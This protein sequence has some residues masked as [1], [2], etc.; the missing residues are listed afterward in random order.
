MGRSNYKMEKIFIVDPV[1]KPRMT[2]RDHWKNRPIV[3]RY[4]A[5]KDMISLQKWEFEF[6]EKGAQVIFQIPMPKSW[7][8]KKKLKMN[9]TDHKQK[10]DLDNLLKALLDALLIDDCMVCNV[11]IT[12]VWGHIGKII[13]KY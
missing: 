1:G 13:I 7:S 5:F 10:P 11:E 9:Q 3:N 4:H 8:M 6:P 2:Q 12:K